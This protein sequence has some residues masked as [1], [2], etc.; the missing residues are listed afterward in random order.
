MENFTIKRLKNYAFCIFAVLGFQQAFSQCPTIV[1]QD[2]F[3]G[4]TLDLA[5]W[6]YQIGDGCDQNLC[7]WGNNELQSYQQ[8]NVVVSNGS[9][10]I[11]AKKERI[12]GTQYT[13]GRITSKGKGDFTYGRFEASIKLPAGDGLWPAFW[14][15][16]TNEQYGTWPQSGEIDI[17]EYVAST[18]NE[19]LGYIHY[20]DLYPNNQSQGNSFEL[21]NEAFYNAF[22]EFAIEWEPGEIRWYMDGILYS[23][24]TPEDI[25]PSNWPFDKDFHFLLNVAVGGNLGG[26]VVDSMLP[27]TMEVDYVR[28]YDTF[29]PSI[30]GDMTVSNQETGVA[31]TIGN[32]PSSVNVNWSVPAGANVMSGQGS[33]SIL[34]DFGTVSGV[35]S[36]S[37]N[38]GCASQSLSIPVE[39]EPPYLKSFSFEN[40]DEPSKVTFVSSTGTLSEVSNP[41]TSAVNSSALSGKY[42]R[43]SQSQ[44]DLIKYSVA[45]ITDASSYVIKDKKFYMDVYSNAPIGTEI[46]LQ[47]ETADATA[48]NFP[49]GRHSRY[50]T[51][52]KENNSWHRLEF[53]LLDE[54]DP[55]A[56]D[57]AVKIMY[58]LFNSNTFTSDTYYYDNLDSYNVDNG[59]VSNQNPTI[60]ISNPI[61]G[62]SFPSGSTVSISADATDSDGIVN[63]VEFFVNGT[64]IGSDS[65]TPFTLD[66]QVIPGISQITAVATDNN[67][68]STTSQAVSITGTSTGSP[69]S[70][71]VSSIITGTADAGKGT[72]YGKA[73]VTILNNLGQPVANATVSG[74]FSGSFSY[75]GSAITASD[76]KAIIQTPVSAKGTLTVEFCVNNVVHSTLSYDSGS[77]V[78]SC[79]NSAQKSSIQ[80]SFTKV[81]SKV[82]NE[83]IAIKFLISP[84]PSRNFVQFST[85]GLEAINGLWIYDMSGKLMLQKFKVNKS[86]ELDISN[87][88]KGVYL[89]KIQDELNNTKTMKLIKK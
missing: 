54:P 42:V 52:I 33:S 18:P 47:L 36:A 28:V 35:V 72:K 75:Q 32:V 64:S 81:N 61:D 8:G 29:K 48:S 45:D 5:K 67:A 55:A 12:R 41:A 73:T 66:W 38:D 70:F 26:T 46:I 31:Y 83:D 43:D 56:L 21:K 63:E 15:L 6:N 4:T 74:T 62:E 44:Y 79:T 78:I 13:S 16:S 57:T 1:W 3:N 25:S 69:T 17:M 80:A 65:L 10:K 68:A 71:Y 40:F 86:G 22:H 84:N 58:L 50:T 89:V 34:V 59:T 77:N 24:K 88:P 49:V 9:L 53:N 60:I 19:I 2:E 85:E 39:V 11:T 82:A 87:F 76:G 23:K 27:A 20:G 7:G 14:M 30:T 37:F 51:A